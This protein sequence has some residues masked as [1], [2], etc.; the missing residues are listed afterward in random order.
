MTMLIRGVELEWLAVLLL[1]G[2][3]LTDTIKI[4]KLSVRPYSW[5]DNHLR[6]PSSKRVFGY[7]YSL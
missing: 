4:D 1:N 5:Y 2:E 3:A 7:V 6:S